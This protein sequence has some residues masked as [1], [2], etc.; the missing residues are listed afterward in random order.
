MSEKPSKDAEMVTNEHVAETMH[1]FVL[2]AAEPAEPGE[3]RKSMLRRAARRLGLPIRRVYGLFY[4]E[5][6]QIAA[7]E[8]L[9]AQQKIIER[10]K[11]R[12]AALRRELE[13]LDR[14]EQDYARDRAE[15]LETA[16]P[17]MAKLAPPD[18]RKGPA[19]RTKG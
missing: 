10:R 14:L 17:L 15:F 13:T 8:Y 3:S 6:R 11:Q 16:H 12:A 1:E 5:A 7:D 18:L 19:V 2:E 9:N 4:R